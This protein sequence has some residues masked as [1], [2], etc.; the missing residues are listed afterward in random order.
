MENRLLCGLHF[1]GEI[2]EQFDVVHG[3]LA[4]QNFKLFNALLLGQAFLSHVPNEATRFAFF[5]CFEHPFARGTRSG[6]GML[7]ATTST[8]T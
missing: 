8:A 2:F 7:A 6:K 5:S 3:D 1:F 4:S